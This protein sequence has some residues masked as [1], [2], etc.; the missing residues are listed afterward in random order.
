M[1]KS[2]KKKLCLDPQYL[3]AFTG[4]TRGVLTRA[5]DH[6]QCGDAPV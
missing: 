4:E 6:C 3:K 1:F 2:S 5:L